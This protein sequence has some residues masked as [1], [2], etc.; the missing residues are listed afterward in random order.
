M[1]NRRGI[2][3]FAIPLNP[4]KFAGEDD[5]GAS[6][7]MVIHLDTLNQPAGR[8]NF[9]ET[10]NNQRV[11]KC[12]PICISRCR[13]GPPVITPWNCVRWLIKDATRR[14]APFKALSTAAAT[15]QPP[16]PRGR[17]R[18][19]ISIIACLTWSTDCNLLLHCIRPSFHRRVWPFASGCR[20]VVCCC[21]SQ[22]LPN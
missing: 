5:N 4:P 3:P 18:P 2:G 19:S 22:P 6:G 15:L 21:R 13:A 7:G 11:D 20:F 10:L 17:P 14:R 9:L 16:S 1:R 12:W 8:I